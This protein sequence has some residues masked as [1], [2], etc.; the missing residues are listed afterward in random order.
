[1]T[2]GIQNK[3]KLSKAFEERTF[4][5]VLKK[6]EREALY[7]RCTSYQL[8]NPEPWCGDLYR[9][10][11]QYF[12]FLS[13]LKVKA[14]LEEL[15]SFGYLETSQSFELIDFGAGTLGATLGAIDFASSGAIKLSSITAIDLFPQTHHVE[16][17]VRLVG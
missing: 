1:M 2:C 5:G 7:R 17:V 6:R 9:P 3:I 10:Y 16:T 8:E 15:K 12:G 11:S 13:A 4:S 14:C